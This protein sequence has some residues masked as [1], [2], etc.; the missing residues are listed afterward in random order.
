MVN[1]TEEDIAEMNQ[2]SDDLANAT[3]VSILDHKVAKAKVRAATPTD[4]HGFMLMLKQYTNLLFA[5]FSANLP[6]YV[7]M[8]D[9][10][11][12]LRDYSLAACKNCKNEH[13]MD[14]PVT[15]QVVCT[16]QND[17]DKGLSRRIYQYGYLIMAKIV[18]H[19]T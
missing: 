11:K 14:Y 18:L 5:L 10:V 9:I 4:A 8:Y 6:M 2:A 12:V 13:P 3:Q 19:H 7:Q 17:R 1:L 16:R 15:I